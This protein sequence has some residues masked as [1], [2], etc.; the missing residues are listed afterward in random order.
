[1]PVATIKTDDTTRV[2]LRSAPP[3]GFVLLRPLPYGKKLERRER[4]SKMLMRVDSGNGRKGGR[5]R[6]RQSSNPD[7]V[8]EFESAQAWAVQFDFSYCIVDHNLTD[9]KDQKLDFANPMTLKM[10]DPR[11]GSE[12]EYAISELNEVEEE[13]DEDVEDFTTVLPLSTGGQ[14]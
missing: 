2:D 13:E 12:I 14:N 4:T 8:M 3:D 5:G 7:A 10:L 9:D 1:M 6:M 11:I